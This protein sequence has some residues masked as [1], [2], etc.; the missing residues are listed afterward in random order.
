M[1]GAGADRGH[2]LGRPE[3]AV[4]LKENPSAAAPARPHPRVGPPPATRTSRGAHMR[5]VTTAVLALILSQAAGAATLHVPA[6]YPTI[7]SATSVASPGDS[8]LVAAGTY[9]ERFT[10]GPGQDGVKIQSESGPAVTIIDG[11]YTGSV[12]SMTLIGPGTELVGFTI[13]HGGHVP[14]GP[15]DLG[16]AIFIDRS[17]PKID[18]DIITQSHSQLGAA[19]SK[20]GSPTITGCV[21]DA[22]VAQGGGGGIYISTGSA[23]I[24]GD[25]FTNNQAVNGG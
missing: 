17:S 5:I 18:D 24:H 16:G 22:N 7:G 19:Y 25:T 10:L 15:L 3:G 23:T 9:D 12:V 2:D 8:I 1:R 21:F 4:S 6:D 14:S 11:G 13:I 20:Q